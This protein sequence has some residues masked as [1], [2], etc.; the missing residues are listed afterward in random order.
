LRKALKL[1]KSMKTIIEAKNLTKVYEG[2]FDTPAL[3]NATLTIGKGESIAIVGKSGSGKSTLMHILATLDRP[4]SGKLI[5]AG[6]PTQELPSG[7]LD[8]LRNRQFGFVFQQF[9][10]NARN[11]C[12]ENVTLPLTIMGIAPSERNQR[13]RVILE[14]VGLSD[15][16]NNKAGDLSGGQ[17]QRLCIA[18][19]LITKP[20]L[21]FADEP[22]GNLD[23]ENGRHIMDLLFR[24]Q[25]AEGI[26]LVIVTHD[27]DLA[28]LCDRVIVLKDGR[29][30]STTERPTQ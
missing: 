24:L 10:I 16:V 14:L 5:I 13:G 15:K 7:E 28:A 12:L 18:R 11:S 29:I 22:T 6:S 4:T 20:Q 3:Q 8:R 27:S 19:A 25:R 30:I 26:T 21:I 1:F 23:S 2:A 17:K 9:F